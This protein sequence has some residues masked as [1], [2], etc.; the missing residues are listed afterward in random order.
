MQAPI[1]K[2]WF[3]QQLEKN[4][5][6]VRGLARHL[7]IDPS[8][9]SRMLAGKRRMKMEEATLIARFLGAP[10]SEVLSHAGVALDTEGIPTR[11]LLAATIGEDGVIERLMQPKPLPQGVIDRAK[12][13]I[14][15]GGNSSVIAAQVRASSGPLAPWDD[16]VVLFGYTESVEPAAI[17]ALSV[18]RLH[19]GT[20]MIA[21]IERARKTGEARVVTFTNET[22]EVVL[23]TATPVLAVLP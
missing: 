14:H 1:D 5:R 2:D 11:I 10:V 7:E 4:N 15:V 22:R 17:G 6:S 20:Q 18:C 3:F 19:E 8:A 13:A 16:A 21:K 23:Q 12:A 9:V